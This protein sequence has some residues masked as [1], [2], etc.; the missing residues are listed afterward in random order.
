[1]DKS[2]RKSARCRWPPTWI[3]WRDHLFSVECR[4]ELPMSLQG[5]S[6]RLEGVK[7]LH[8]QL[9]RW[10]QW[11]KWPVTLAV[12]GGLLA[13]AFFVNRTMQAERASEEGGDEVQAKRRAKNGVVT[14][15]SEEVEEHGIECEA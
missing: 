11:L 9:G 15:S 2:L 5:S 1:M 3:G 8:M 13:G 7:R 14:L 4:F 6:P 12:V 10:S